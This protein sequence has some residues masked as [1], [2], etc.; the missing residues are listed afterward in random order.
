M[1]SSTYVALSGQIALERR[2][3]TLAQNIANA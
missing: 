1:E 3:A 2:M